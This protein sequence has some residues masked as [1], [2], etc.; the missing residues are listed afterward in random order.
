MYNS[1]CVCIHIFY[2]IVTVLHVLWCT[3]KQVLYI[4]YQLI[5]LQNLS[6]VRPETMYAGCHANFHLSCNLPSYSYSNSC[7]F[8]IQADWKKQLFENL[9]FISNLSGNRF[10]RLLSVVSWSS[11]GSVTNLAFWDWC[12]CRISFADPVAVRHSLAI[13]SDLATRDPYSVAMALGQYVYFIWQCC[14]SW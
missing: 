7:L 2:S 3:M 5:A 4:K 8:T 10:T 6:F 11:I 13:I 12:D 1:I 9:F 14:V